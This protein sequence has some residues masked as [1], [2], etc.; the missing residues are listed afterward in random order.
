MGVCEW[1]CLLVLVCCSCAAKEVEVGAWERVVRGRA[2]GDTGDRGEDASLLA[3]IGH[4]IQPLQHRAVSPLNGFGFEVSLR[5]IASLC[6]VLSPY[7]HDTSE[8]R[9]EW[10]AANVARSSCFARGTETWPG[11]DGMLVHPHPVL[12][13][14]NRYENENGCHDE[15]ET[16]CSV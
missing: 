6:S 10:S 15:G 9:A 8:V 4:P 3:S 12:H 11:R 7:S 5:I 16:R 1:V 2:L 14:Q 13:M